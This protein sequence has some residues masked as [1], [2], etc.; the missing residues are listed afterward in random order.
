MTSSGMLCI[1][2]LRDPISDDLLEYAWL[3]YGLGGMGGYDEPF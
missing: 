3:S 1:Q 2:C